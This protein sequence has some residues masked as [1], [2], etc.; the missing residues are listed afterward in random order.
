MPSSSGWCCLTVV[1]IFLVAAAA[2]AQGVAG[3]VTG[4]LEIAKERFAL[5]HA[6]ALME[7]DPFSNGEKENLVV[8][9]S[10]IPVPDEMRK[11]S[12]DWRIWAADQAGAGSIH[13]LIGHF[14]EKPASPAD[15]RYHCISPSINVEHQG[16]SRE[17]ST[18]DCTRWKRIQ[19]D[20]KP[21]VRQSPSRL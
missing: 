14:E 8:L 4:T 2:M 7:E 17:P 10:D 21:M 19:P 16:G 18:Y 9:L 3:G 1:S 5:K 6:F 11:A 20:R 12:N 13:G 15:Y